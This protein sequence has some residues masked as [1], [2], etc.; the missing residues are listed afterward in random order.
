MLL[1]FVCSEAIFLIYLPSAWLQNFSIQ[2]LSDKE[3]QSGSFLFCKLKLASRDPLLMV[4]W[5]FKLQTFLWRRPNSDP[6]CWLY[7]VRIFFYCCCWCSDGSNLF[8]IQSAFWILSCKQK[9]KGLVFKIFG[10]FTDYI[11][12]EIECIYSLSGIPFPLWLLY[13][14]SFLLPFL[15][16]VS[17]FVF[18]MHIAFCS[19]CCDSLYQ[20]DLSVAEMILCHLVAK[21]CSMH[22]TFI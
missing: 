19:F 12:S 10:E 9:K 13:F 22:Y 18:Y 7:L 11:L 2:V 15:I 6:H 5:W 16:Q 21:T 8:E 1:P 4:D 3:I 17:A 14:S 20:D